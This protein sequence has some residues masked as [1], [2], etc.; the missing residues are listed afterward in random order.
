[1]TTCETLHV[2]VQENNMYSQTLS[3]TVSGWKCTGNL[4]I[5]Y[6]SCHHSQAQARFIHCVI[7][8]PILNLET[9][10]CTC[11]FCRTVTQLH[12]TCFP[13]KF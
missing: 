10:M 7:P 5:Y 8:Q 9:E 2:A 3:I 4:F 11:A 12:V 6:I 13:N 1:M